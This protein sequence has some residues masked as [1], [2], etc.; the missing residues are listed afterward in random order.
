[1]KQF[2]NRKHGMTGKH[3]TRKANAFREYTEIFGHSFDCG[4]L[5]E[6]DSDGIHMLIIVFCDLTGLGEMLW[7]IGI[8]VVCGR[9]NLDCQ[10]NLLIEKDIL[11][12]VKQR[13]GAAQT[14]QIDPVSRVIRHV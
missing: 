13:I 9:K 10:R 5:G 8:H 7:S 6:F 14:A 3:K 1:M 2:V 11:L 12:T 4:F